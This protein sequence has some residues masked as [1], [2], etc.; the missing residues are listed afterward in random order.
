MEF[1]NAAEIEARRRISMSKALTGK[2]Q[3]WHSER[4]KKNNPTR[5]AHV[6]QMIRDSWKDGSRSHQTPYGRSE[7]RGGKGK[8]PTEG[9]GFAWEILQR[10]GFQ[11]E[12]YFFLTDEEQERFGQAKNFT[13]DFFSKKKLLV[14]ELDGK[15]HKNK[16]RRESNARK[17]VYLAEKGIRVVRLPGMPE[18]SSLLRAAGVVSFRS[19]SRTAEK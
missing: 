7:E 4:M 10:F 5:L 3:P 13:A 9:E 2:P 17:D 18:R 15:S 12:V 19:K 8:P 14:V 11:R 1:E 16:D 6:R